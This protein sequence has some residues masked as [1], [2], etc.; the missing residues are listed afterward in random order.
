MFF[1]FIL[2]FLAKSSLL[3]EEY[4]LDFTKYPNYYF[5]ISKEKFELR[6]STW[7]DPIATFEEITDGIINLNFI[8]Q[9]KTNGKSSILLYPYS[10]PTA[11]VNI[12]IKNS[13]PSTNLPIYLS[14]YSDGSYSS[15]VTFNVDSPNLLKVEKAYSGADIKIKTIEDNQLLTHIL[16]V[17]QRNKF[18][19]CFNS[20]DCS[21]RD[22]ITIQSDET[23]LSSII[24]ANL[25]SHVKTLIS[26]NIIEYVKIYFNGETE[27]FKINGLP[28]NQIEKI[29]LIGQSKEAPQIINL[30]ENEDTESLKKWE[31]QYIQFSVPDNSNYIFNEI[32]VKDTENVFPEN[33]N[34]QIGTSH[35]IRSSSS[36]N[37]PFQ[38]ARSI[39]L[40]F[41]DISFSF[42]TNNDV[43]ILSKGDDISITGSSQNLIATVPF[44]KAKTFRISA[45]NE[46]NPAKNKVIIKGDNSN[47]AF[48][49]FIESS[50]QILIEFIEWIDSKYSDFNF[51]FYSKNS[52]DLIINCDS[53][54]SIKYRH[55]NLEQTRLFWES[56]FE[57]N[58]YVFCLSS[59]KC[60]QPSH[61]RRDIL[62][63]PITGENLTDITAKLHNQLDE[64][65][66]IDI[67]YLYL[68]LNGEDDGIQLD[69][70]P[71]LSGE[72]LAKIGFVNDDSNSNLIDVNIKSMP[73][74]E[75]N[76]WEIKK[77]KLNI[78]PSVSNYWIKDLYS[79][80]DGQIS[81]EGIEVVQKNFLVHV[82][83]SESDQRVLIAENS[84][85]CLNIT[86]Q[87]N[88]HVTLSVKTGKTP[89]NLIF[90]HKDSVKRT[91][92]IEVNIESADEDSYDV[93]ILFS[94]SWHQ[95]PIKSVG[96]IK[97]NADSSTNIVFHS[98]PE[99]IKVE[100]FKN[101]KI[102]EKIPTNC[103][104]DKLLIC[105]G[106]DE[107]S[108]QGKFLLNDDELLLAAST[109]KVFS[110]IIELIS[111]NE[112][113]YYKYIKLLL[114]P[115]S[116]DYIIKFQD[117]PTER[118]NKL[119]LFGFVNTI[120][121]LL[122]EE[123]ETENIKYLIL[124]S[125]KF[126]QIKGNTKNYTF[127]DLTVNDT[128]NVFPD[129][130]T[131]DNSNIII[132]TAHLIVFT[133]ANI[134]G[135]TPVKG[136]IETLIFEVN[137]NLLNQDYVI[138]MRGKS[139]F[140]N[141]SLTN[142]YGGG[143]PSIGDVPCSNYFIHLNGP[144]IKNH[145]VYI[146]RLDSRTDFTNISFIIDKFNNVVPIQ[147]ECK[148]AEKTREFNYNF[149][150]D[151]SSYYELINN[152][153]NVFSINETINDPSPLPTQS[154]SPSET[155]SKS[156][157]PLSTPSFS[158]SQSST[159][160]KTTIPEQPILSF[161]SNS[162]SF[163]MNS[164]GYIESDTEKVIVDNNSQI[165]TAVSF[166]SKN[167]EIKE[168]ENA[169]SSLIPLYFIANSD[170]STIKINENVKASNIGFYSDKSPTLLINKNDIPLSFLNRIMNGG[171]IT[172]S[173]NDTDKE[174]PTK[175][176]KFKEITNQKGEF[177]LKV[178]SSIISV[179]LKN[180]VMNYYSKLRINRND[181]VSK[182][183]LLD[184]DDDDIQLTVTNDFNVSS[185]SE[186][187]IE[188]LI[189][190]G[191]LNI[192]SDS[193]LNIEKDAQFNQNSCIE[194]FVS[195][196]EPN[197][198]PIFKIGNVKNAPPKIVFVPN[199]ESESF[200]N[201][202]LIR[203]EN[204]NCDNFADNVFFRQNGED[205]LIDKNSCN[206]VSENIVF[207][208]SSTKKKDDKKGGKLSTG[209]IVGIV[210]ACIVV[211]IIIIV[212][213]VL[214][215]KRKRN[216]KLISEKE[217][218]DN[219]EHSDSVAI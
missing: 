133:N 118:F 39:D 32:F 106:S 5:V 217:N 121:V 125:V 71:Y 41:F 28:Y 132:K 128:T 149:F 110:E 56:P 68:F 141:A 206:V 146:N 12:T 61:Y 98:I 180:L 202:N 74:T 169:Y 135:L 72:N 134:L 4:T 40:A 91:S 120:K 181:D 190:D 168:S 66:H 177:Q 138:S 205:V 23:Y 172:I 199:N 14:C 191:K 88:D 33:A 102:I 6:T 188:N 100:I 20:S 37:S 116:D 185:Q 70:L 26:T 73:N 189:L 112:N 1:S 197:S 179:S 27:A 139:I 8:A 124:N 142:D 173:L 96:S 95:I 108:S 194:I 210:I 140:F 3:N 162:E 90:D 218:K 165:I 42:E 103:D 178:P 153:C 49:L 157:L 183:S 11:T 92:S 147:F 192:Y 114:L 59:E 52:D 187:E 117:F 19:I 111:S 80:D 17:N 50:D 44:L 30:Q 2:C 104:Q 126:N 78:D 77:C 34:Y 97:I 51:D 21:E 136:H 127:Q 48:D 204:I 215:N 170:E 46:K 87:R 22:G 55:Y 54:Q 171:S 152:S 69:L 182:A 219:D 107:C 24:E 176:L 113:K 29:E 196:S 159:P 79:I 201:L 18:V 209:A 145:R 81:G 193:H 31:I 64:L 166:N 207:S 57:E 94:E 213:A 84:F 25:S 160:L 175:S 123:T 148:G 109:E 16:P 158:P 67:H 167:I 62:Q 122:T 85:S 211:V 163:E 150:S 63:V 7:G 130:Y 65:K 45:K 86:F 203:A 174:N 198:N 83:V 15:S 76:I 115:N 208:Y 38:G 137:P 214:L 10:N 36:G 143:S 154:K 35:E 216:E 75:D 156:P 200:S 119:E 58:N 43:T 131:H 105:Y 151:D 144:N 82:D 89:H 195:N 164:N 184:D 212:V 161:T 186:V 60:D 129:V 93:P 13:D 9:I 99:K 47:K 101:D 155:P 53:K